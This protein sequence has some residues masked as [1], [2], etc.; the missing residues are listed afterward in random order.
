[1]QKRIKLP[2]GQSNFICYFSSERSEI[3]DCLNTPKHLFVSITTLSEDGLGQKSQ[4]TSQLYHQLSRSFTLQLKCPSS[5]EKLSIVAVSAAAA[6][7]SFQFDIQTWSKN[8]GLHNF[9]PVFKPDTQIQVWRKQ[10]F[11]SLIL[12][13]LSWGNNKDISFRSRTKKYNHI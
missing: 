7:S 11:Q 4:E 1:M 13:K 12:N 6:F 5:E 3:S 10:S 9:D 2:E 8:V